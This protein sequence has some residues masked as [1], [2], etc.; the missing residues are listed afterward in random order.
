MYRELFLK[1][2]FIHALIFLWHLSFEDD[3]NTMFYGHENNMGGVFYLTQ[4]VS[5]HRSAKKKSQGSCSYTDS[6]YCRHLP[7]K[8][9]NGEVCVGC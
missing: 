3:H 1:V 8:I 6:E 7:E 9:E 5:E 2:Y 4:L